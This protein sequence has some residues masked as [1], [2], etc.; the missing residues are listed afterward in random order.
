MKKLFN[1]I[2][3]TVV[4]II[5]AVGYSNISVAHEHTEKR[6]L[7]NKLKKE[8]TELGCDP[9]KKKGLLSKIDYWIIDL[10]KQLEEC[11]KDSEEEKAKKVAIES[12]K[13]EILKEL[14][15]LGVKPKEDTKDIDTNEEIIEIR[16]L[17]DTK[18]KKAK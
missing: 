1:K 11:K 15:K 14:E 7:I 13:K 17:L 3:I 5:I 4:T 2:A 10:K 18:K 12:V 16:I 9:V 6:Q 8:I